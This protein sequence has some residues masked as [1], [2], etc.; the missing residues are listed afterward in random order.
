LVLSLVT[1][2]TRY[3]VR[4]WD[5]IG[6]ERVTNRGA[7]RESLDDRILPCYSISMAVGAV[8]I[9]QVYKCRC[10]RLLVIRTLT[11]SG[12]MI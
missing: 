5:S 3:I 10:L 2:T 1:D 4:R 9:V 6:E 7:S 8:R 12:R 11:R